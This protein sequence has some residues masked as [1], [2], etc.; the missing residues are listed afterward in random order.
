MKKQAIILPVLAFLSLII[1]G[2]KGAVT[3]SEYS[4]SSSESSSSSAPA[5]YTITWKNFDGAVIETDEGVIEGTMPTY[6]GPVPEKLEDSQFYYVFSG[7]TPEVSLA[8]AN[9]E[10]TATFTNELRSYNVIWKDE[11]G[12]VLETDESVPYGS[13]PEFNKDEPT[14]EMTVE[15]TFEF[16]GWDNEV[17][18]VTGDA[19]YT[20]TYKTSPRKYNVTWKAEDGSEIKTEEVAYGETPVFTGELPTKDSTAQYEYTFENWTPNIAPITGDVEY[21]PLFKEEVRTY[22][23]KWVNFDGEVLELD[24]DVEY[25]QSPVY[26]GEMP[27]RPDGHGVNYSWKGWSPV[28]ETVE[29]DQ[30]YTAIYDYEAYFSFSLMDYELAA[31]AKQSDLKGAPWVNTNLQG[32]INKIQKPSLKDDFYASVN[33][34]DIKY[35]NPGPFEIDDQV[36]YDAYQAIDNGEAVT[37]NSDFMYTFMSKLGNSEATNIASYI[38]NLD[39]DTYLNSK[40]IFNSPSSYLKLISD[41]S[42]Y[43]VVFSDGY[44]NSPVGLQTL[45]YFIRSRGGSSYKTATNNVISKLN[46]TLN[47]S[48]TSELID[49]AATIDNDLVKSVI[50]SHNTIIGNKV[51]AY[52]VDTVPWEELK[53]A[54]LDLGL[55]SNETI[56]IRTMNNSPITRLFTYYPVLKADELKAD[57]QLRLA[58]DNRFLLGPTTYKSIASQLSSI[59][60]GYFFPGDNTLAYKSDW[61]LPS[62]MIKVVTEY[63]YQQAYIELTTGNDIKEEVAD[64]IDDILEG[65]KEMMDE[66]DW[67]SDDTKDKIKLKL[68]KMAYC[69]C[70]PDV[71]G[72]LP[73][74]DQTGMQEA[75][76]F[77][78][79]KRYNE[80]LTQESINHIQQDNFS[81]AWDYMTIDTV[82]AFYA[83]NYNSFVILNGIVPGFVGESVEEFYGMLGFVIGHEIT[84]AFDSSGSRYDENGAYKDIMTSEDRT[85]FNNKVNRLI[86]FFDQINLYDHNYINGNKVNGEATADMGGIKVALQLAKKIDNF[87]YD[88]FFRAA[89]RTWCRQPYSSSSANSMLSNEHP[90]PYIRVN[91]T[92]AQFDEFVETYDIGPG[93]GMYIPENQRVKIW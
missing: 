71:Y 4:S 52:T 15:S 81:W 59:E 41:G 5:T 88:K 57:L 8:N 50:N 32:Q 77:E 13:M 51:T 23:V 49:G 40:E 83:P 43:E 72:Y 14:K 28:I 3:T 12:T 79:Y 44:Y 29:S 47:L 69:A 38:N 9:V 18:E 62:E 65:Y 2:C 11:D 54:L 68:E 39:L 33:Y 46:T 82:N 48:L 87:D 34:E 53:N 26:N 91:M 25:G 58:F 78:L 75:S 36:G 80:A 55:D 90:F 21:S 93:D 76:S 42:E 17:V 20:A 10:Y 85:A 19:V 1:T 66:I 64:L 27:T 45:W 7:W 67:L 35:G 16:D 61:Q 22:T 37:T 24:E 6:D 63:A 30:V 84:H 56:N 74:I 89:A 86:D 92:L 73:E 60:S 70:Y 31:G